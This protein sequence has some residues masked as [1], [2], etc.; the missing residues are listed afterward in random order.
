MHRVDRNLAIPVP[1]PDGEQVGAAD[2]SAERVEAFVGR[3]D[4]EVT[5]E[6]PQVSCFL[7]TAQER[8]HG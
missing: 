6:C 4:I 2:Q 1:T 5:F 7:S 3:W 8:I